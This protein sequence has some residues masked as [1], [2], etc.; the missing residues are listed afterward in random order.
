MIDTS[1]T[2]STIENLLAD[3]LAGELTDEQTAQFTRLLATNNEA[4]DQYLR[5]IFVTGLLHESGRCLTEESGIAGKTHC[6]D[7]ANA[8]S[9]AGER[10]WD[11]AL[12]W[13]GRMFKLG[14]RLLCAG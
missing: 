2:S 11:F 6:D 5:L 14:W 3:L 7:A 4:L 13:R 9:N 12:P 8:T 1:T 10:T